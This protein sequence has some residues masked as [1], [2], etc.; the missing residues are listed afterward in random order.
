MAGTPVAD[1]ELLG[2]ARNGDVAA[3]TVLVRRYEE[4]VYNLAWRLTGSRDAAEDV[5]QETFLA[6]YEGL[7]RFRGDSAIYTWLYRIALN[8]SLSA[9]RRAT[10]SKEFAAGG[11]DASPVDT[12]PDG[13]DGPDGRLMRDE[14][15]EAVQ[16]ALMK[17][18]EDFRAVVVLKDI[19]GLEYEDIAEV[20]SIPV[21]TVK[22][23]LHRGRLEL[24]ETLR[25]Y[26]S[27][28]KY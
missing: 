28:G 17:L 26:L 13:H 6:F 10:R 22:S 3:F 12:A 5:A 25:P 11:D 7:R 21:G 19:D 16:R 15:A 14:R 9:R 23:R 8:Q 4:R 27:D 20:L 1:M 18:S 2:R 24:R